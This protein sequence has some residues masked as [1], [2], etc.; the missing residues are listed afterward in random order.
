MSFTKNF[1]S[2]IIFMDE[3]ERVTFDKKRITRFQPFEHG[4][5]IFGG[6]FG[7]EGKGKEVDATAEK[8]KKLGLKILS[9]RGQGSGNAGHTVVVDGKSMIFII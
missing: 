7:D 6:Y 1:S 4:T 9:A 8:Y 2:E 5:V 3:E